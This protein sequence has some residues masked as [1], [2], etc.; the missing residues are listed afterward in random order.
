VTHLSLLDEKD[1]PCI[2]KLWVWDSWFE[3]C[4]YIW[5]RWP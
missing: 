3:R 4:G 5:R 2:S 1:L